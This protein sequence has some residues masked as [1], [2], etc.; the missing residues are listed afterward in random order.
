M[1]GTGMVASGTVLSLEMGTLAGAAAMPETHAAAGTQDTGKQ[2]F[3]T[4][5]TGSV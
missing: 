4:V 5:S 1:T 2:A 3:S